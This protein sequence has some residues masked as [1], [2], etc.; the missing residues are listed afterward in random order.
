MTE[1]RRARWCLL[2]LLGLAAIALALPPAPFPRTHGGTW[3]QRAWAEP[4]PG[5]PEIEPGQAV[6]GLFPVLVPAPVADAAGAARPPVSPVIF[7]GQRIPLRF[8]HV[9]HLRLPGAPGC[10]DCHAGAL[11]STSSLDNLIPTEQACRACHAIDRSQPEK[12]VAAGAPPARCDACHVGYQPGAR[13]V[14][15]VSIPAP[16]L[17]FPHRVHMER[18]MA[19][20]GCHGDL[21]AEGVALAT[22]AQL[23][24]MA[25]CLSCHISGSRRPSAACTTCHLADAGG[26]VRTVYPDGKLL[27]AGGQRGDAHDLGFRTN[28]AAAAENDPSYCASCHQKSFC[29]DCHRGE[30]K[31]MDF[32]GGNYVALHALDAR[33]NVPDC[34]ACHR[35]QT[36]CTGCHARTGVSADG[37]GSEFASGDAARSFHPPGWAEPGGAGPG[38]HEFEARRNI[39]ACVSCHREQFCVTCHTAEPG[40]MGVSPHPPGWAASRRCRALLARNPRVCLRCHLTPDELRCAP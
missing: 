19:C 39:D 7:P 18:G 3:E 11:R 1:P 21:A 33:R 40:S 16:N 14:D 23:P 6:P 26:L 30:I 35:L 13:L 15:R 2:G 22:R 29:V 17:K 24:K 38:H 10:A 37:R 5:D 25:T 34:S 8:S 27:P 20:T 4:P 31:P 36:F 32:H 28:H 12:A 9:L